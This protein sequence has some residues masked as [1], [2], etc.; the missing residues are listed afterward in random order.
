MRWKDIL[1][2]LKL[3]A[4]Q[5]VGRNLRIVA[6]WWTLCTFVY[7]N[8]QCL[9]SGQLLLIYK[10]VEG[11]PATEK[12]SMLPAVCWDSRLRWWGPR[13]NSP[14]VRP[15]NRDCDWSL[16]SDL[17]GMTCHYYVNQNGKQAE[18]Q[19]LDETS[20]RW[21]CLKLYSESKPTLSNWAQK[22]FLR[23]NFVSIVCERT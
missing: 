19:N 17:K 12:S 11:A 6:Q 4:Y 14:I 21:S 2:Y 20:H 9:F 3:C 18:F 22:N 13:G 5:I 8:L 15:L 16:N 10:I 1:I 23:Q 7:F